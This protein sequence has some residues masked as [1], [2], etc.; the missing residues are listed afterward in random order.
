[1]L[2]VYTYIIILH[3]ICVFRFIYTYENMDSYG[4]YVS[5]F[6]YSV[7]ILAIIVSHFV[8]IMPLNDDLMFTYSPSPSP[9]P[10]SN[11]TREPYCIYCYNTAVEHLS[12]IREKDVCFYCE[13]A[14]QFFICTDCHTERSSLVYPC[15]SCRTLLSHTRDISLTDL[16]QLEHPEHMK[17][18]CCASCKQYQD[19]S[20]RLIE[21]FCSDCYSNRDNCYLCD[22]CF[23]EYTT[24]YKACLICCKEIVYLY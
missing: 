6:I 17:H 5:P 19:I 18:K 2:I 7:S 14:S 21:H 3:F 15:I 16:F 1:M 22:T 4:S 23:W 10:P 24:R 11:H 8:Q 12:Y 9:S 20:F 13:G